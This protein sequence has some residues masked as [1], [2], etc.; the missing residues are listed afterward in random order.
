MGGGA[1]WTRVN[2]LPSNNLDISPV[3]T[4]KGGKK[5]PKMAAVNTHKLLEP[6]SLVV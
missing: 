2:K 3:M 6:T 5:P 4:E 1:G